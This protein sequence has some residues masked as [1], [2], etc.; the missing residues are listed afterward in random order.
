MA[1]YIYVSQITHIC[2]MYG[3]S[4]LHVRIT[5]CIHVKYNFEDHN[6]Q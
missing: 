3:P 4:E 6:K 1:P 5:Q 2:A